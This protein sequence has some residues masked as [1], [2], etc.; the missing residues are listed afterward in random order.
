MSLSLTL[1]ARLVCPVICIDLQIFTV[2]F[3]VIKWN[4]LFT[5]PKL[6]AKQSGQLLCLFFTNLWG[7]FITNLLS[8]GLFSHLMRQQQEQDATHMFHKHVGNMTSAVCLSL[9]LS[10][11]NSM[12]WNDS[13][14]HLPLLDSCSISL[15]VPLSLL[16]SLHLSVVETAAFVKS[17]HRTNSKN[18][19]N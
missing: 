19:R 11:C 5:C 16:P 10:L 8:Q 15:S 9:S 14:K 6:I 7:H 17:K 4:L 2:C 18:F 1:D 12:P 3:D 13:R